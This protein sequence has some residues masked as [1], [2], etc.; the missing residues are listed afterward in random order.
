MALPVLL[1]AAALLILDR[2]GAKLEDKGGAAVP[3]AGDREGP[4][5]AGPMGLHEPSDEALGHGHEVAEVRPS[6]LLWLGTGLLAGIAVLLTALWFL[7][8][9]LSGRAATFTLRP[10][11]LPRIGDAAFN[12]LF[13]DRAPGLYPDPDLDLR[14]FLAAQEAKH[15]GYGWADRQAGVA[16][17]PLER[18]MALIAERGLPAWDFPDVQGGAAAAPVSPGD[19]GTGGEDRRGKWE[20]GGSG[21][22]APGTDGGGS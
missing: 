18:A 1:A 16:T 12:A 2:L 22:G 17:L 19:T 11:A 4:R 20:A 15:V 13:R 14:D 5:Q 3:S 10:A 9:A 6:I 8:E 7:Q 21:A